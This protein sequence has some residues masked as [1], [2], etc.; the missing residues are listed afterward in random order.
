[1]CCYGTFEWRVM[2][3][4]LMNAPSMFQCVMNNV[5]MPLL[6]KGV[7]VYL[8]DILIYSKTQEEHNALL[9]QVFAR[10]DKHKLFVKEAKCA[11]YLESIKFLRH[12]VS[13]AGVA[14]E[15]GKV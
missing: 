10:L 12:V 8:Y 7:L 14:M 3:F 13:A 4:G 6:D 15:P 11:L 5:F 9:T 1:M 2:P